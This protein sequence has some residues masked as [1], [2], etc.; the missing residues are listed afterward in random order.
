MPPEAKDPDAEDR[1]RFRHMLDTARDA[2]S[3]AE[4]RTRADLDQDAMLLRTLGQCVQVIG[5]AG[6]RMSPRG[7]AV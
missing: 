5:E 4:G 2:E 3:F 6:A 1:V 7:A